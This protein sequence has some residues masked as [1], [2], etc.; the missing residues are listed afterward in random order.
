MLPFQS[1]R[2]NHHFRRL[3]NLQ[4]MVASNHMLAQVGLTSILDWLSDSGIS[5]SPWLVVAVPHPTSLSACF[6]VPDEEKRGQKKD[7]PGIPPNWQ[8]PR[9]GKRIRT[10]PGG[11]DRFLLVRECSQS[12]S[13]GGG[14]Q[15]KKSRNPSSSM[16]GSSKVALAGHKSVHVHA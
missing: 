9:E 3:E 5:P 2:P 16:D 4:P 8:C 13:I 6:R 7:R 11:I 1:V 12:A 14:L 10:R 15:S